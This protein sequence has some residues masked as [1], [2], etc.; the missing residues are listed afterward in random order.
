VQIEAVDADGT[1]QKCEESGQGLVFVSR[2]AE[3][4]RIGFHEFHSKNVIIALRENMGRAVSV[5]QL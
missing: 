4:G 1:Q 2:R 5:R 3:I